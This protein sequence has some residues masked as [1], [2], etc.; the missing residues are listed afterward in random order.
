MLHKQI[1]IF[2]YCPCFKVNMIELIIRAIFSLTSSKSWWLSYKLQNVL[3]N[4]CSIW[5]LP[6]TL[7][8]IAVVPH[9]GWEHVCSDL[10]SQITFL[11]SSRWQ[12][13]RDSILV[14]LFNPW[15][16]NQIDS[17]SRQPLSCPSDSSPA[18]QGRVSF[19]TIKE[20]NTPLTVASVPFWVAVRNGLFNISCSFWP[21]EAVE[22]VGFQ[23]LPWAG[24]HT[25]LWRSISSLLNPANIAD[26]CLFKPHLRGSHLGTLAIDLKWLWCPARDRGHSS[27]LA[28]FPSPSPPPHH[29]QALVG[30][31][32]F[33]E[34]SWC[35]CLAH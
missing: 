1:P 4:P 2:H 19:F 30:T 6:N 5:R 18:S 20:A 23:T 11:H 12:C 28:S 34:A 32:K 21:A 25:D 35:I 13:H 27:S 15:H 16:G 9:S 22:G 14:T 31:A 29:E 24:L 26:R 8:Q 3:L 7:A 10:R 17:M 33:Y